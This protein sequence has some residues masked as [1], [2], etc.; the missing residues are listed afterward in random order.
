MGYTVLLCKPTKFRLR[1]GMLFEFTPVH[2]VIILRTNQWLYIRRVVLNDVTA[3]CFEPVDCTQYSRRRV[4]SHRA[5]VTA[6]NHFKDVQTWQTRRENNKAMKTGAVFA[7][8][9]P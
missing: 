9:L 1:C 6:V 5:A 7:S 8:S 4:R 2:V 3:C